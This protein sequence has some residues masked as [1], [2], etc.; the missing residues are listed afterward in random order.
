MMHPGYPSLERR[1]QECCGSEHTSSSRLVSE[2]S[3]SALLL[4]GCLV[5]NSS[6]PRTTRFRC[7]PASRLRLSHFPGRVTRS[8]VGG[9]IKVAIL[10]WFFFFTPF[11]PTAPPW[12]LGPSC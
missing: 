6:G 3:L 10:R 7:P 1:Q 11:A 8:P 5:R 9:W 4:H 12:C 2:H